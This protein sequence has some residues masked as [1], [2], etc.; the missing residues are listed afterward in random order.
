MVIHQAEIKDK[1]QIIN[2]SGYGDYISTRVAKIIA[3]KTWRWTLLNLAWTAGPVTC[4]AIY[5]GHRFGFGDGPSLQQV[6]YFASYTA[7]V[8]IFAVIASIAHD[9]FYQ[10][11]VER[12]KVLLLESINTLFH[13]ILHSRDI[14]LQRLPSTE[15]K[16]MAAYYTLQSAGSS[17]RAVKEAALD[18]TNS[19]KISNAIERIYSYDEQG[20]RSLIDEVKEECREELESVGENLLVVAPVTYDL[21]KQRMR[22]EVPSVR[23]GRIRDNGFIQRTLDAAADEDTGLMTVGDAYEIATLLFELL[24]GR[25]FT[26]LKAR[27]TGDNIVS[28]AKKELDRA[29]RK[30]KK[31]LRA[32]NNAIRL[33]L[34]EINSKQLL[35]RLPESNNFSSNLLRSLLRD[36][37]GLTVEEKKNYSE[38]YNNILSLHKKASDAAENFERLRDIYLNRIKEKGKKIS[39]AIEKSDIGRY[40]FYLTKET[41]ALEDREKLTFAHLIDSL[42]EA[43]LYNKEEEEVKSCAIELASAMEQLLPIED[44]EVQS[45]IE[46]TSALQIGYLK[47]TFTPAALVGSAQIVVKSMHLSDRTAAHQL[48]K[49]LI[50]NYDIQLSDAMI[51]LFQREFNA[52]GE[53]LK[54]LRETSNR[55]PERRHR[56]LP[57]EG[58]L[59]PFNE[60]F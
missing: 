6:V 45:A 52:D 27:F 54:K 15:R 14:S 8:G 25:E 31:S 53:Y 20:M 16:I 5:I 56:T 11:R 38:E 29:K 22:G 35:D 46:N 33:L 17:T 59:P 34:E 10:P 50:D 57:K 60:L 40:G 44:A 26:L 21:L 42:D 49:N 43:K 13:Y 1:G 19:H 36:L 58:D 55:Q 48:A 3:R 9:A 41:I 28:R 51:E 32:R 39:L 30:L 12:E 2:H 37:R 23:A 4:I 47:P 24:N 7:V 18:L